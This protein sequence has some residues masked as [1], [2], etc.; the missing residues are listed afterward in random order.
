[1]RSRPGAG[2]LQC[3]MKSDGNRS[4]SESLSLSLNKKESR[5]EMANLEQVMTS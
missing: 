3:V 1:M 2:G 5:K 4:R